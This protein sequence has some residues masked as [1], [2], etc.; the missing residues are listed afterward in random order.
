MIL[1]IQSADT[2][3]QRIDEPVVPLIPPLPFPQSSSSGDWR[4]VLPASPPES[5]HPKK[6]LI[7][8]M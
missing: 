6:F 3:S 7:M 8:K 4:L 5:Y 1:P 2:A